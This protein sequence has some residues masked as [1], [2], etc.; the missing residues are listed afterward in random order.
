M[1]KVTCTDATSRRKEPKSMP[2]KLQCTLIAASRAVS[3]DNRRLLCHQS[4]PLQREPQTDYTTAVAP[5][6][7][8][9]RFLWQSC[10]FACTLGSLSSV[11]W[12]VTHRRALGENKA[13]PG[14][15]P[16]RPWHLGSKCCPPFPPAV[17]KWESRTAR[18]C[19]VSTPARGRSGTAQRQLWAHRG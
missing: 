1:L 16:A 8:G 11:W 15:C 4:S 14:A 3:S 9:S 6:E 10:P 7:M 13:R 2:G 19:Q 12:V 5:K 17:S 18:S